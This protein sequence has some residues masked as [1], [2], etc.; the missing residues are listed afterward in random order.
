MRPPSPGLSIQSRPI[1]LDTS[2]T[3]FLYGVVGPSEQGGLFVFNFE[4]LK[5][6]ARSGPTEQGTRDLTA[7][8]S[9]RQR[10][11]VKLYFGISHIDHYASRP[12]A[13]TGV[14]VVKAL[15][16]KDI[17]EESSRLREVLPMSSAIACQRSQDPSLR[18]RCCSWLRTSHVYLQ[19]SP[20][21][22]QPPS[23]SRPGCALA[24]SHSEHLRVAFLPLTSPLP[25]CRPAKMSNLEIALRYVL[26]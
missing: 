25:S 1:Q 21:R 22:R 12:F 11:T 3:P 9:R 18:T 14:P 19:R 10:R 26:A 13:R 15:G 2:R 5:K 7:P 4:I 23:R 8:R 20:R 17:G 6:E 24:A 16:A